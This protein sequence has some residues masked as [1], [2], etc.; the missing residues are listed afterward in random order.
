[1]SAGVPVEVITVLNRLGL[2]M[3][4]NTLHNWFQDVAKERKK[5]IQEEVR[6]SEGRLYLWGLTGGHKLDPAAGPGLLL[7]RDRQH[8]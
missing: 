2:S 4:Y 6:E 1:M 5:K 3:S 7:L 8:Q